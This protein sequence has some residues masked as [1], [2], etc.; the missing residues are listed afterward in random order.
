MN[1]TSP[2]L[3]GVY[4]LVG[5]MNLNQMKD[6]EESVADRNIVQVPGHERGV[7]VSYCFSFF[8]V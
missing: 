6:W 3:H 4:S 8:D 1:K 7:F 5:L 2:C